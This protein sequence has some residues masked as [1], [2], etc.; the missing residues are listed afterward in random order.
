MQRRDH[1]TVMISRRGQDVVECGARMIISP[2]G[3]RLPAAFSLTTRQ[4]PRDGGVP[5]PQV[6]HG[7]ATVKPT[8]TT[9][10]CRTPRCGT[11]PPTVKPSAPGGADSSTPRSFLVGT[12]T[13]G[14]IRCS[15]PGGVPVNFLSVGPRRKGC[16]QGA[17]AKCASMRQPLPVVSTIVMTYW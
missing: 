11:T 5:P 14:P 2:C 1:G 13:P 17:R 16:A 15:C 6:R 8:P 7:G 12:K 10:E 3:R 4:F 9:E